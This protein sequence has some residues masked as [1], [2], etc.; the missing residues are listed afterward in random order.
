MIVKPIGVIRTPFKHKKDTPIQPY[1]S[2]KIGKVE[3]FK[4]I[5]TRTVRYWGFLSYNSYL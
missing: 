1:K 5:P 4:K 3:A 2:D